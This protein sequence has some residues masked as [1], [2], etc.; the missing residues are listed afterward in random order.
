MSWRTA[1]LFH[2]FLPTSNGSEVLSIE[3]RNVARLPAAAFSMNLPQLILS[4]RGSGM[5]REGKYVIFGFR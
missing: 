1:A 2:D 5:V 4:I 3:L